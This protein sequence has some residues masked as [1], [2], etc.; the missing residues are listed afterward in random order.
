MLVFTYQLDHIHTTLQEFFLN[1]M[2]NCSYWYCLFLLQ[3][4]YKE[5]IS[6]LI[7][8]HFSSTVTPR[9]LLLC[10]YLKPR[11]ELLR[12]CAPNLYLFLKNEPTFSLRRLEA[13]SVSLLSFLLLSISISVSEVT[14]AK[15]DGAPNMASSWA[16]LICSSLLAFIYCHYKS[17]IRN[18]RTYSC[19]RENDKEEKHR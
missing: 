3:H 10:K 4:Y 11:E 7:N 1:Q 19:L 5:T 13:W 15:S 14:D 2:V 17:Y 9:T 16:T 6:F 18:Y 8:L 12:F